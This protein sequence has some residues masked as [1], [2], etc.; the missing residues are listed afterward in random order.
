[1]VAPLVRLLC[2]LRPAVPAVVASRPGLASQWCRGQSHHVSGSRPLPPP[3]RLPPRAPL[4]SRCSIWSCGWTP[5]AWR[6][7]RSRIRCS[8]RSSRRRRRRSRARPVL[9]HLA[10][11][12]PPP[13]PAGGC[14]PSTGRLTRRSGGCRAAAVSC[15][16][17][18]GSAGWE[19][20]CGWV[21]APCR[22]AALGVLEP[23]APCAPACRSTPCSP[24]P[25]Q[26]RASRA[27]WC[28]CAWRRRP[29]P[30]PPPRRRCA[31]PRDTWTGGHAG[32][33]QGCAAKGGHGKTHLHR[34]PLP[35]VSWPA[36][37]L[38]PP[39]SIPF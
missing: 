8:R 10:P 23:P 32:R 3:R 15:G 39:P 7:R 20:V 6:S 4:L 16:C 14:W 18:G 17:D 34:P 29:A 33:W 24:P 35:A 11:P 2:L 30:R 38:A 25:R 28:C 37:T 31:W 19:G 13:P 9:R 21:P 5:P 26:R 12:P 22:A 27:A 36:P 1:M